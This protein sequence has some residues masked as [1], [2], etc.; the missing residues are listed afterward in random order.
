MQDLISM[1]VEHPPFRDLE[2]RL[3]GGRSLLRGGT[4]GLL[5]G[6]PRRQHWPRAPG[7]RSSACSRRSSRPKRSSRTSAFFSPELPLL[8]P[9]WE[10]VEEDELPDAEIRS[11]RLA[12]LKYLASRRDRSA[13]RTACRLIVAPVQALLQQTPSPSVLGENTLA[14]RPGLVRAAGGSRRAGWRSGAFRTSARRKCRAKSAAG[15][16]FSTSFPTPPQ[17]PVRVEFF[18]NEIESIRTYDPATQASTTEIPEA[19][20]TAVPEHH[21]EEASPASPC[22]RF[23]APR[24]P[25]RR[26]LGVAEGAGGD[27]RARRRLR[28]PSGAGRGALGGGFA[29]RPGLALPDAAR[30]RRC[31][32]FSAA[33]RR[34]STCIRSSASAT[35]SRPRS[36]N[37]ST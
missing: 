27:F 8:F 14:L 29:P 37:S 23:V 11:Q 25:A 7:A 26:H 30:R 16:A 28:E 20:I 3:R 19:S 13:S 36:R 33:S 4:L 15:A 31:R 5:R 34:L 12:V 32:E 10:T 21:G 22:V 6:L 2:A 35:N 1:L 17:A 9:A 24:P 18:G